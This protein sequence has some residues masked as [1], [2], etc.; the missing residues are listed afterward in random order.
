MRQRNIGDGERI[1]IVDSHAISSDGLCGNS[2][3]ILSDDDTFWFVG[4][5]DRSVGDVGVQDFIF[6]DRDESAREHDT[7]V[8]VDDT[9]RSDF[10]DDVVVF[11]F[12][13]VIVVVVKFIFA[14]NTMN[15]EIFQADVPMTNI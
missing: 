4:D 9:L 2:R 14:P 5:N 8:A 7:V 12:V 11:V 6:I 13:V 10:I 3:W 1:I 15:T